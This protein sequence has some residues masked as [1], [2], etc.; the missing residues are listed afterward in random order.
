MGARGEGAAE[1]VRREVRD[2]PGLE[3]GDVV[4]AGSQPWPYPNQLMVGF[5]AQW[6]SGELQLQPEELAEARWFDPADRP[7]IPPKGS[8]AWRLIRGAF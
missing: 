5:V 8:M 1:G 7:T 4:Y 6:K 2:Q 3:G